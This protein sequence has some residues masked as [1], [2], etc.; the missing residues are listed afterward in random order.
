MINTCLTSDTNS[1]LVV[2]YA[3]RLTRTSH[4]NVSGSLRIKAN[5]T[6]RQAS[7]KGA[8]S[9]P[10]QCN[11]HLT[12]AIHTYP[13]T[14]GASGENTGSHAKQSAILLGAVR[15]VTHPTSLLHRLTGC[16]N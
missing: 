9:A 6:Q 16:S 14:P 11:G 2:S 7:T 13:G 5:A 3:E 1:R 15:Q 8:L 4:Q 12:L 10:S